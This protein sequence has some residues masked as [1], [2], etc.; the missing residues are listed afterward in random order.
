[1]LI[2]SDGKEVDG[3]EVDE[4]VVEEIV[5]EEIVV[6][7]IVVEEIVVEEIEVDGIELDDIVSDGIEVDD[8]VSDVIEVDEIESDGS[9]RYLFLYTIL[10]KSFIFAF[11]KKLLETCTRTIIIIANSCKKIFILNFKLILFE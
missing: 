3:I 8:I 6:D 10:L 11:S 1:V 5:V 2:V 9:F 4:I 7:E